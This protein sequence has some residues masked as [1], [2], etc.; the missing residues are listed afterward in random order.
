MSAVFC[1]ML[2]SFFVLV[3][4][5]GGSISRNARR[6][7]AVRRCGPADL[8]R[9]RGRRALIG[10]QQHEVEEVDAVQGVEAGPLE[11]VADVVREAERAAVAGRQPGRRERARARVTQDVLARIAA[12]HRGVQRVD[13]VRRRLVRP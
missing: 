1:T 9:G 10:R 6:V 11:L 12:D 4:E 7:G 13:R 3:H 8:G 5:S 2:G